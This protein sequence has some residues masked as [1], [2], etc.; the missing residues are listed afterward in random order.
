MMASHSLRILHIMRAPVG[1]LFRH[2]VDL[3]REQ[4]ARGHAVGI[5]AD[6]S[7]G[8]SSAAATLAELSA[9][10]ALS[11]TRVPM[12][13]QLGPLDWS[14]LTHVKQRAADTDA[15]VLHGHGAKGGAYARLAGGR[16][17]TAYTPHGGSL[18]YSPR[19]PAGLAYFAIERWL[20]GRTGVALF[21]SAFAQEAFRRFIGEPPFS[22]VV[23]NGISKEELVPVT[24]N[25][26]AADIIFIGEL[27][28]RKG[29]DT[30]LQSL[31]VLATEG[32]R[33]KAI[34]YGEGPD[35]K[36]CEEMSD[37]LGLTEQIGFPGET[38]PR[39]AFQTGRLLV[40]PSRQESL[41]YIVLE[42]AAAR[43]PMVTTAVG[44]IPEI[45][46][47]D[48]EALIPPGDRDKLVTAI[49]QMRSD[50][51][52]D[53]VERLHERVARY[54]SVDVMTDSVLAA[55]DEARHKRR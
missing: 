33:G 14:A 12:S 21:E 23:H 15:D 26:D 41:P 11:V 1:G 13:R 46:G 39:P 28:W 52:S 37:N 7:T 42:A 54:F 9:T 43:V 51:R 4:S 49:K 40:I 36:A 6:S 8:S 10:L 44:G 29:I 17:L 31:A 47:P 16:A 20:R 32:W 45:F 35:R 3:A 2:V 19:S 22:R 5:I 55:Y 27:R 53:L 30:L 25:S 50:G 38:R 18:F 48:A 24:P 34:I